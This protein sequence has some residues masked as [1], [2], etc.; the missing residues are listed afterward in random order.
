MSRPEAPINISVTFRHTESTDALK[1]YA[2]EKLTSC[3]KKYIGHPADVHVV[4]LVEKR[5][6]IAEVRVH[7][8]GHDAQAKA[9]NVDLYA[10]IDKVSDMIDSQLRKQKERTIKSK[11]QG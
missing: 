8:K 11:H 1:N 9:V 2:D 6:H 3:L 7:S 5:D 10:A 4:L